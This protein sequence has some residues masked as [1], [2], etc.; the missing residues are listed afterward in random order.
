[1]DKGKYGDEPLIVFKTAA[2]F[3]V[4]ILSSEFSEQLQKVSSLGMLMGQSSCF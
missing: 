4:K 1:M 3:L 2:C